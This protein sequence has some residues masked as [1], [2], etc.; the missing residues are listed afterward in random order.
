MISGM[1]TQK[2]GEMVGGP[3]IGSAVIRSKRKAL[4]ALFPHAVSLEKEGRREIFDAFLHAARAS[5]RSGFMWRYIE[6]FLS[7]L[8]DEDAPVPP[9]WAVILASPHI[10][11]WQFENGAQLIQLWAA[12]ASEVEYTD[13]VDQSIVD[14]L[15]QIACWKSPPIPPGMWPWLNR[16]PNLPPVCSGRYWGTKQA[17]F[18]TVRALGDIEILTSYLL[19]V[20]SEWDF[21]M[22]RGFDEMCAS[23]REDFGGEGMGHHR[24]DLLQRLD[25]V[26]GELERGLEYFRQHKPGLE[27]DRILFRQG[28]YGRLKEILLEV[29][30]EAID[31]PTSV[32]VPDR[33]SF[34][35]S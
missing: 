23:I 27:E 24:K 18:Q 25:H 1:I 12:A 8:L 11:W 21:V 29:D 31:M 9:K 13:D 4:T 5:A 33:K 10:P 22:P 19:L 28:Q 16:R 34:P 15:L 6:P 26:L 20:W 35:V 32:S 14:T 3:G 30:K 7:A 2:L 17:V